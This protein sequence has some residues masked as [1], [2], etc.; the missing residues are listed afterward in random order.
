[1]IVVISSHRTFEEQVELHKKAEE[2]HG[3]GK[4]SLWVAPAGYSEHHTG[5]VFDL[6]DRERPETDDE[7]PF[8]NTPA[9]AW[10]RGNGEKFGFELSFPKG[11]GQ[12][13]SYEPWH[14]RFVGDERSKRV[15]H[16][17]LPKKTLV[18]IKSVLKAIG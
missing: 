10:L 5:Y 16:P 9:F 18:L 11:N 1:M 13:V 4:G 17:P 2:R 15:F 7:P 8:E 12:N 6:A 3:K 14:W